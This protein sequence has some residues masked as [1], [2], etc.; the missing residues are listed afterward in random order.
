M[1]QPHHP[2]PRS[3]LSYPPHPLPHTHADPEQLF[4]NYKL[5]SVAH[6]NWRTMSYKAINTFID[7]LFAF[8]I[9]M[10]IMHRLACLRDDVVF[11]VYLYQRRIYR[12][13]YSRVNEFGQCIAPTEGMIKEAEAEKTGGAA[14]AVAAEALTAT[15]EPKSMADD[16]VGRVT[17]RNRRGAREKK[18]GAADTP[19]PVPGGSGETTVRKRRGARD[20]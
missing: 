5:Q 18:R 1:P 9:K 4:I 13:D 11:F 6:L 7:D 16:G 12:T 17:A 20:K 3:R 15:V 2:L 8:V 19:G 10:P 14:A